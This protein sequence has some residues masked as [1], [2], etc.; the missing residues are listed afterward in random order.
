MPDFLT[1]QVLVIALAVLATLAVGGV[2]YALFFNRVRGKSSAERRMEA[3]AERSGSAAVVVRAADAV[4]RRRRSVQESLKEAE[5]REKAKASKRTSPPLELRLQQA[6]LDWTKQRFFIFGMICG[7]GFFAIAWYLK[8][9]I[10]PAI[11]IGIAGAAGFPFWV[12][13]FLRKRRFKAFVKEFVNA[14]DIIVRGVKAGL[15]LN[16]CLRIIASESAEPVKSEFRVLHERQTMGQ[17]I[18][19]AIQ[20]LPE[21][22][23][24]AEANFF[25]IAITIQQQAG[26]NLSE[27]LGNLSRVLRERSKMR[28]KVKAMSME[29][30]ASAWIIGSLP[31]IVGALVY[32]TSPDY[33]TPL[34]TEQIG[35]VILIASAFWMSCG[36]FVM[37]R[38]INFDI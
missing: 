19:E 31:V 3:V 1:P 32:L 18:S 20:G 15:P 16:D 36:V 7:V 27:A 24:L 33:I 22:I 35:H 26:G 28:S 21:R 6:G 2:A 12:V 30:K 8:A 25:A 10:L 34:F 9:P 14:V 5:V 37:K 4:A 13:N 23:P 11:G 29:A 38:M 17:S